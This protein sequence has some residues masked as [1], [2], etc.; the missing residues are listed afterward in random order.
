MSQSRFVPIARRA[1]LSGAAILLLVPIVHCG[2]A[3]ATERS[4][5]VAR[6]EYLVTITACDDCHTP[7][8]LGPSGPEPD[9]SRRL[10]GH[11]EGCPLAPPATWPDGW[12]WAGSPTNTAFAGPWG[13]SYARNLTP[14]LSTG[15]GVYTEASFVAA[16]RD[17]KQMGA[18]RP[19]L[20][21]MPWPSFGKMT[22]EDLKAIY[23][24][25]RSLPPIRNQVPEATI[26]SPA[27]ATG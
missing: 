22:D 14:D 8:K 25:L 15:I 23:S 27:G 6:G 17:G 20:P 3:R 19:I 13:V 4:T 10:S 7:F 18:G 26:A 2:R 11:P 1:L 12:T 16:I 5:R 21:P 24:Y 9:M